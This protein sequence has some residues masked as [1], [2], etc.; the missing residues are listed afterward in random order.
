MSFSACSAELAKT[1]KPDFDKSFTANVQIAAGGESFS[2]KLTRKAE[3]CWSFAV[4]EPFALEGLTVTAENGE[5]TFSFLG[6]ECFADFS[7]KATSAVKL[8]CDAYEAAADNMESFEN[9]FFEGTAAN[10]AYSVILGADGTP[11]TITAGGISA[12]LSEWTEGAEAED[13]MI[14]TIE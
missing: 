1:V 10:G 12:R 5:T 3:N 9:G 6:Y 14:I 7:D 8:L 4:S 11:E 13:D 2:G